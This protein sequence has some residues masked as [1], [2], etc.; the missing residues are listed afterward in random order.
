MHAVQI[1]YSDSNLFPSVEEVNS[2]YQLAI[3]ITAKALATELIVF[4]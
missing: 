4:P 3:D 1:R 2:Y